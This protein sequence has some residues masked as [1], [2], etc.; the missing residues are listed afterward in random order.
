MLEPAF[1][2]GGNF[3]VEHYAKPGAAQHPSCDATVVVAKDAVKLFRELGM[4]AKWRWKKFG[5]T[6]LWQDAAASD[7]G[8][9]GDDEVEVR[10][11]QAQMVQ[12]RACLDNGLRWRCILCLSSAEDLKTG[13]T[14]KCLDKH[15]MNMTHK[16]LTVGPLT[17]CDRCGLYSAL[18]CRGLRGACK[19]SMTYPSVR[20]TTA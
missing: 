16:L 14:I 8:E 12:H 2:R 11:G 6:A 7:A 20:V 17:F 1:K 5:R 18:R 4:A 9:D 10:R 3:I 13:R 19:G 15:E